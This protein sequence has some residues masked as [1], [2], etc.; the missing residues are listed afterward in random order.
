MASH[1]MAGAV[2][3]GVKQSC[4]VCSIEGSR[5]EST[6]PEFLG[7]FT[8]GC[9]PRGGESAIRY[10]EDEVNDVNKTRKG[11]FFHFGESFFTH[12]IFQVSEMEDVGRAV[13]WYSLNYM[14][15]GL[16]IDLHAQPLF[17][18]LR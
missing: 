3:L 15:A 17:D 7:G 18:V 11:N 4:G 16:Y 14:L 13:F 9:N 12:C 10:G 6:G 8:G 5:L 2:Y 1:A